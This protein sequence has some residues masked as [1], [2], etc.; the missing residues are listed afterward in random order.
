MKLK[1]PPLESFKFSC[2]TDKFKISGA[3]SKVFDV[4]ISYLIQKPCSKFVTFYADFCRLTNIFADF[5]ICFTK[6]C[7]L[8]YTQIYC[9]FTVPS[10]HNLIG[11]LFFTLIPP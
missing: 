8:Q 4:F 7:S 6:S 11:F 1:Y 9:L 3:F 2:L 5:T 10:I